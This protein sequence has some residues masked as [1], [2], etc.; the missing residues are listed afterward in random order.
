MNYRLIAIQVG[1]L[2]KYYTCKNEI[3]RAANSVFNFSR[4]DFPNGAITS[5]RAKLIHDWILTL[6]KQKMNNDERNELLRKFL[7]LITPEDKV[8][9]VEK[10]LREAGV[11][12]HIDETLNEFYSKNYHHLICKHCLQLYKQRNYFHAVFEAAKVYNKMV[13]EKAQ[14]DKDGYALMMDVWDC[15][16][17]L[18]ITPCKTETDKNVQEGLK[19]LSAGLMRAIRNPTAHEPALDWPISKDDCLDLLSFISFLL[20]Q[21]DKAVYYKGN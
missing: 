7:R 20:R 18:K 14:S 13:K 12:L 16:G 5:E 8:A 6:A 19:F 10:I 3:E 11:N 21:L 4:E 2:L 9:E 1:D 15:K 17:V